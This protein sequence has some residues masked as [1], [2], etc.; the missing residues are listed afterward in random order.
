MNKINVKMNRP[1]QAHPSVIDIG[2]IAMYKYWCDYVKSK[3]G[4]RVK[5]AYE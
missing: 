2:K 1:M 4:K 3:Y 5:H